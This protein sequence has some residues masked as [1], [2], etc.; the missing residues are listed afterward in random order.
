M[1]PRKPGSQEPHGSHARGSW[2]KFRKAPV[3]VELA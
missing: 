3:Y 2:G 1:I